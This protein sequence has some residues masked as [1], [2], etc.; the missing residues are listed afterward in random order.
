MRTPALLVVALLLAVSPELHAYTQPASAD[1]EAL[2]A[3]ED[4]WDQALY[5]RDVA[6]VDQVLAEE[7]V[8]TYPDGTRGDRAKELAL[9]AAFNQ[10]VDSSTHDDMTVRVYGD[11]AVVWFTLRL[12]GPKDGRPTVLLLR[13]VDVFVRRAGRWQCVSSQS[14]RATP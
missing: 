14:T 6:F 1:E 8:A 11:T 4:A 3:L 7:F 13:Y 9:V 10:Q 12:T 5:R 2:V